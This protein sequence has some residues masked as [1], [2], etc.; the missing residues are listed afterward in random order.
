MDDSFTG[1]ERELIGSLRAKYGGGAR[2]VAAPAPDQ[3]QDVAPGSGGAVGAALA[4]VRG[5]Q[6]Q[7]QATEL[8]GG[9]AAGVRVCAACSGAG[10]L[11]E[12]YNH[13]VLEVRGAL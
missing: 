5:V 7:Q 2:D 4:A 1:P 6:E 12:T 13:R 9:A 11:Q 3:D 8:A 10:R